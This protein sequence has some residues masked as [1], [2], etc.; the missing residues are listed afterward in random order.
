[1]SLV[2]VGLGRVGL[3]TAALLASAGHRVIGVERDPAL[4][5]A[6]LGRTAGAAEPGLRELLDGVAIE[7]VERPVPAGV[8]VLCV[9]TPVRDGA[10]DLGDLFAAASEVD[11]FA[12]EGALVIVESTVP[13]GT[14][15]LLAGKHPRLAWVVAPE[16]VLPGDALREIASNDR[17]VGGPPEAAARAA[18]LLRSICS[19]RVEVVDART[20]ELAKLVE[21][22]SRDV[23]LAFANTVAALAESFG[24]ALPQLLEVVRR[25]PRVRLLQPGIGVG[26]HCLPVDPWFLI[27]ARPDLADLLRAARSIND[28]V[29]ATWV[30]R[31]ARHPGTIGLLGLSY[32]PD[33]DDRRASPALSIARTLAET[34]DVLVHDPHGT[35]ADLR[36]G[37]LDEVLARDV[38][39][40]LVAH[41]AYRGLRA[42]V[43]RG[44]VVVDAAGGWT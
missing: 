2:V 39:V 28:A 44:A 23:E 42:R 24:V 31:I 25:H 8:Y 27:E 14:T 18:R 10:A 4:R 7:V 41:R 21:N 38:V 3:P 5:E 35:E 43:R 40:H 15:D 11:R 1:M 22:A 16:R 37:S 9:G 12:P 34:R 32:K 17:V 6:V 20:A 13:V 19:G 36:S 26:G 29:P 33:T 30:E